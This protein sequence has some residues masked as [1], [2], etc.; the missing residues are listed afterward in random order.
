MSKNYSYRNLIMWQRSQELALSVIRLTRSFPQHWANAILGRQIISSVTSIGANIAEG[1]GRY[2]PG[3][4]RNHLSIARVSA[5]ETD[6]WLDLLRRDGLISSAEELPLHNECGE[7]TAMLTRKILDL[8]R[9]E[10]E[11]QHKLRETPEHYNVINNLDV[12]PF[13]FVPDDYQQE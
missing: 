11:S 10:Q 9:L 3:A 1:H 5:A 12:P 4:H 13:P 7:I 8:E 2:T 6:S